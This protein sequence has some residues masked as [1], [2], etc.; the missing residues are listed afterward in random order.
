M[1]YRYVG[2]TGLKIAAVSLGCM[3]FGGEGTSEQEAGAILD[4]YVEAGGNYLDTANNYDGSEEIIG[5]WLKDRGLRPQIVL[6]TKVRF[7]T[8][9]RGP[10]DVGLTRKHIHQ[11]IDDSL[12]R[13]QTDYVDLYQAHCWDQ[14]T[15]IEE[16]VRAFDDLVTAGKIRYAGCSNYASW[17]LMKA[18]GTADMVGRARFVCIQNQ[19]SLLTRTAE[20]E[21][22]PLCRCEGV[23][24]TAWSPLAGGW[25]SGKYRRE[26]LPPADS[27]LA[28]AATTQQEWEKVMEVDVHA[29]IPHPRKKLV[30]QALA[31]QQHQAALDRRWR[32]IDALADVGKARG[33]TPSQ[34]ALAWMLAQD[35]VTAPI[36]GCRTLQ[37][38]KDNLGAIGWQLATQ[39][40]DWLNQVSDPG[41][42]YPHDFFRQYGVWR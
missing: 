25:L 19:Y 28:H 36:C 1:E 33:K 10:N 16:T 17:H 15:A 9:A 26:S 41:L 40:L 37:Q 5:R 23:G 32:I 3:T 29:T 20:W 22:L 30:E 13:L 12:R 31:R 21:V 7:P 6:A 38:L 24:F 35:G 11:A 27:R 18:L 2:R 34:V 42:P 8:A 4:H 39:E 14:C